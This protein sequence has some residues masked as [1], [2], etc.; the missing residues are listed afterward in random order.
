M[1]VPKVQ[2]SSLHVFLSIVRELLYFCQANDMHDTSCQPRIT[3][4]STV[5]AQE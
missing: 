2:L 4:A 3:L 1:Q 5:V